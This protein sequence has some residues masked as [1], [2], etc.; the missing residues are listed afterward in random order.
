[1][2][3][4]S[5]SSEETTVKAQALRNCKA[6]IAQGGVKRRRS[7]PTRANC[8]ARVWWAGR[9]REKGK[10][11]SVVLLR[12]LPCGTATTNSGNGDDTGHDDCNS[13]RGSDKRNGGR[14]NNIG[15]VHAY[16]HAYDGHS[17]P[18]PCPRT[19]TSLCL[20]LDEAIWAM[21][22]ALLLPLEWLQSGLS[23][24]SHS[25]PC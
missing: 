18:A 23:F 10:G 2:V 13:G 20:G 19:M 6:A 8:P 24:S 11:R 3:L 21:C 12:P 14:G 15:D 5:V 7:L 25:P 9:K 1:M 17:R 4:V 22:T 16:E